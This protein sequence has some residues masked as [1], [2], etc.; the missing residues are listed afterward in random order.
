MG[1]EK[2][3]NKDTMSKN[4]LDNTA[5]AKM[6]EVTQK[7]AMDFADG[8]REYLTQAKTERENHDLI[9]ALAKKQGFVPV[10]KVQALKAGDKIYFSYR[11]KA[12]ALAVIGEE[13]LEKGLLVIASHADS[14]R[15]D[16]KARPV[17]EADGMTWFKTHYYGGVKKYQW[18]AIPLA[19]HGVVIKKDG[20]KLEICLGEDPKELAFTI[21]DLL[22]HLAKDQMEKKMNEAITAEHLNI[23]VGSHPHDQEEDPFKSALMALLKAKYDIE[24]EDFASAELTAVPAFPA[25]DLGFDRSMIGAYGQDDRI[26]VYTSLQAILGLEKPKKTAVCIFADKEEIGSTGN[27][28]LQSLLMEDIFVQL[29]HLSGKDDYYS[30]RQAMTN[31]CALSADVNAA[32]DPGHPDVFEKLNCSFLGRGVVLTKFTGSRGKAESNDANPEYLAKIRKLFAE[33][34]VIWQVGELGK[35]DIGGGGTVAMYMSYF[36]MEVVDCGPAI[37]SMHSPFEVSSKADIYMA[38][39]AYQSFFQSFA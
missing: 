26:C 17:Y 16:L 35:V 38:Y 3:R 4:Q 29:L 39:R 34:D 36:G 21:T 2:G 32:V 27:T 1:E 22:P 24:E 5:W 28:G 10:E 7:V 18:V 30:L 25:R 9:L 14:P 20:S 11:G 6:D 13:A 31:S 33:N 19:L 23:L 12:A 8:Y 37:L 15:I